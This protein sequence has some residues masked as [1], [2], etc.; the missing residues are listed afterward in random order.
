M[1]FHN[2]KKYFD[3][4]GA[5]EYFKSM[6]KDYQIKR[7]RN[8][9]KPEEYRTERSPVYCSGAVSAGFLRRAAYRVC[10]GVPA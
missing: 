8:T 1:D 7:K 9:E 4:L 6:M 10:R 2:S 5:T 3:L